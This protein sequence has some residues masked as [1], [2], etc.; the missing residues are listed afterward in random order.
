MKV[1]TLYLSTTA[2]YANK[3]TNK[4]NLAQVRWNI[5]WREVFGS[6]TGNCRVRTKLLSASS[7]S[8]TWTANVGSVR[9]SFSSIST[10]SSN[11]FNLGYLRPQ[12]DYTAASGTIYTYLDL[13]TL[14]SNGATIIIPNSNSEFVLTLLNATETQM[15]NVPEYQVWFYFEV[16]DEDEGD[17]DS[18][19][20]AKF[21]NPR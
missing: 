9:A 3:P 17:S 5:N 8:I 19:K 18:G 10:S 12:N 21:L 7:N 15:S 4:S 1:Y 6:R 20:P 11:G 2:T 16:D 14:T 13:D